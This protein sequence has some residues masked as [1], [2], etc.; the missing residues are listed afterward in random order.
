MTD[1]FIKPTFRSFLSDKEVEQLL[2]TVPLVNVWNHAAM[3]STAQIKL[4]QLVYFINELNESLIANGT[5]GYFWLMMS[6]NMRKG[7]ENLIGFSNIPTAPVSFSDMIDGQLPQGLS[8]INCFGVLMSKW[9]LYHRL[10]HPEN[11]ILLGCNDK[12]EDISHYARI[13]LSDK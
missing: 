13:N 1:P 11:V 3:P 7:F 4:M 12:L 9:R 2:E 5:R 10:N 6:P 8:T